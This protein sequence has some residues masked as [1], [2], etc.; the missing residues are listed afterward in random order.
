MPKVIM[1]SK[2]FLKGHPKQGKE[3]SFPSKIQNALL[4]F[5]DPEYKNLSKKLHTIRAGKRHK[6]GDRVSLRF[7]IDKPYRSSQVE[8]A[9]V[10]IKKVYD[11][12]FRKT[13][14]EG[15]YILHFSIVDKEGNCLFYGRAF[16]NEPFKGQG[17]K[18]RFSIQSQLYKLANNDG[19]TANDFV[20]WFLPYKDFDGQIICWIDP[21]YSDL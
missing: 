3:T 10:R 11:F 17:L 7:W 13:M 14:F 9:I 2:V 8:F 4:D 12:Q 5:T 20:Q 16:E 18:H 6:E 1:I 15:K 19:L 21:E